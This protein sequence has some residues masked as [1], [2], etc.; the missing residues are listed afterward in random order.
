MVEDGIGLRVEPGRS[1]TH[2]NRIDALYSATEAPRGAIATE[3]LVPG[4]MAVEDSG[5]RR[6]CVTRY[7]LQPRQLEAEYGQP[8]CFF[9]LFVGVN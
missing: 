3:V 5:S 9:Q 7:W 6:K 8:R 4:V 1:G 2:L